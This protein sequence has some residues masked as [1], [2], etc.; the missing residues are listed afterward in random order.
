MVVRRSSTTTDYSP[1]SKIG[2]AK[3]ILGIC[4]KNLESKEKKTDGIFFCS[5]TRTT[6]IVRNILKIN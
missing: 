2:K 4:I 1:I 3:R 5:L 6:R